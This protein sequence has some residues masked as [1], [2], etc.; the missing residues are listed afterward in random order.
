MMTLGKIKNVLDAVKDDD[1]R[2]IIED[3]NN[4]GYYISNFSLDVSE[5][6]TKE[7]IFNIFSNGGFED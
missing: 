4:K 1:V 6:G 2:I 3:E 5:D 7:V